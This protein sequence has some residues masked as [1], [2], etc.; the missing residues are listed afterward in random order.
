MK[1][2][3][4]KEFTAIFGLVEA[5]I[6]FIFVVGAAITMSLVP[7]LDILMAF[8]IIM[9]GGLMFITGWGE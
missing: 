9:S 3:S 6:A 2:E 7:T 8:L 4:I 5:F 1:M